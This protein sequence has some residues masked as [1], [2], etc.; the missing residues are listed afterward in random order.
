EAGDWTVYLLLVTLAVTPA[1]RLFDWSKLIQVRRMI[2]LSAL[3]YILLHFTLYIVD[4]RLDL[5]FVAREI[6]LRIYL[7]IGFAALLGL[8]VL[9]LTSTDG[10]IKRLGAIRWN[11]LH[12]ILYVIT[13]FAILHYY[14]QS[15]VDVTQPV[16]MSGFF[17]WLMGYRIMAAR[18]IKEG[19]VPL[20]LLAVAA[21]LL[22]VAV[23]AAWYGLATGIG[24]RRVLLANLDFSVSI[25]PAWW[26]L[27]A[28]L[29]VAAAST[30]RKHFAAPRPPARRT[31]TA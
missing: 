16:L 10:M 5:G 6:V 24:A 27:A 18:G 29:A 11:R 22:T 12:R 30:F 26:V 21:A 1:R 8:V 9:G 28:G 14:M 13:P 23:E 2:G 15:K 25:R 3:A 17:F 19:L 7:T 4:S 20:L 31:A